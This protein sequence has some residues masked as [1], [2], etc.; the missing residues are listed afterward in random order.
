MST[1]AAHLGVSVVFDTNAIHTESERFL[2]RKEVAD[3]IRTNAG[4]TDLELTCYL[5]EVVR[6]ERQF[7]MSRAV[8]AWLPTI[9]KI[10][11]FLD[12]DLQITEA[13]VASRVALNI[14]EQIREL[15]LVTLPFVAAGTDWRAMMLNAIYRN[16][17]FSPSN[18]EKGFRDALIVEAFCN[19]VSNAPTSSHPHH[20]VLLSADHLLTRAV[21]QRLGTR[22]DIRI[23]NAAEEFR[24]WLD[25][26]RS[27]LSET[28]VQMLQVRAEAY[29]YAPGSVNSLFAD[30]KVWQEIETRYVSELS[31][32]P[33]VADGNFLAHFD[34]GPP[35]FHEYNANRF[36]WI[37]RVYAHMSAYRLEHVE[38]YTFVYKY[39]DGASYGVPGT[40]VP[41]T[42]TRPA[43][44][45]KNVV[46]TG[47]AEFDVAWSVDISST[48][49]QFSAGQ[50]ERI[51]HISTSWPTG[52]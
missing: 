9:R 46:T 43:H 48:E 7:Q 22:T 5:P 1:T 44:T 19:L 31:A 3:L 28:F 34:V 39:V 50:I 38:A 45:E 18:A 8:L 16:P 11:R 20:F 36:L 40:K 42:D 13:L 35:R 10:E 6:H 47:I 23:F 15:G 25:I 26:N 33:P 27:L 24:G 17:P 49:H 4:N 21:G 37:S 51:D 2:V 41:I 32:Y 52:A 30:Q 14:D 12:R 29:F